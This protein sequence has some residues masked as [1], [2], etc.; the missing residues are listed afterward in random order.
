VKVGAE[1]EDREP[2]Y[3]AAKRLE[4]NLESVL[5]AMFDKAPGP[6]MLVHGDPW[7]HNLMFRRDAETGK[8]TGVALV[9]LA[10][11]RPD[12]VATD[13]Y[14]FITTSMNTE[15]RRSGRGM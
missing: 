8:L 10:G 6:M 12:V 13:L 14:G 3:I 7:A 15:V 5:D 9:D 2:T 4:N 11:Y 1:S